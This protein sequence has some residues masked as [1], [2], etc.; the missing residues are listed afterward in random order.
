M[1]LRRE[2]SE[3]KTDRSERTRTIL[4]AHFPE[5]DNDGLAA[6]RRTQRVRA[7]RDRVAREEAIG[8]DAI[9]RVIGRLVN[10]FERRG[11]RPVDLAHL[12]DTLLRLARDD[13]ALLAQLVKQPPAALP[14]RRLDILSSTPRGTAEECGRRERET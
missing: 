3:G 11:A 8:R 9:G 7:C 1:G 14:A 2:V 10:L 13:D 4:V 6:L 12:D 5:R